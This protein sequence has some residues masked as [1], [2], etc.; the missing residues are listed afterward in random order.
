MK[1]F[2]DF[3]KILEATSMGQHGVSFGDIIEGNNFNNLPSDIYQKLKSNTELSSKEI[4]VVLDMADNKKQVAQFLGKDVL[5]TLADEDVRFLIFNQKDESVRDAIIDALLEFKTDLSSDNL[6]TILLMAEKPIEILRKL[7][8]IRVNV[9]EP[10]H[11]REIMNGLKNT[12]D[13]NDYGKFRRIFKR[14]RAF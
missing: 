13:I 4:R 14:F 8:E 6:R 10:N 9:L 1:T 7:G 11:V 3:V 2:Y 12:L 5:K